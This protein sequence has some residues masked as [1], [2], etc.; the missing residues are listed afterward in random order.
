MADFGLRDL[1]QR[2]ERLL[3]G[4]L[5]VAAHHASMVM[6]FFIAV[7]LLDFGYFFE[8]VCAFMIVAR[9]AQLEQI[10]AQGVRDHAKARQAH[11]CRAEH[12]VER[13][14]ERD[15]HARRD[16]DANRVV[17][18]RPEQVLLDIADDCLLSWIAVDTS[19]QVTFIRTISADSIATSVPAPMAMLHLPWQAPG[20]R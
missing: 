10:Q 9:I 20:H 14:A 4:R 16:G 5:T 6:V 17:E 11:G 3:H 18:K 1:G 19:K 8:M 2:L 13:Q 15:E 12:G 7:F